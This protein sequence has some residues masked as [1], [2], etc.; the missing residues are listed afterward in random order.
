MERI[1]QIIATQNDFP[2]QISFSYGISEI[3]HLEEVEEALSR[4]DQEMY[5]RKRQRGQ[6]II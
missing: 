3:K 1:Q 4:A 2:F 6:N 5:T